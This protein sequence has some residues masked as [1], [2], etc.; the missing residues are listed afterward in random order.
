L[1]SG[2]RQLERKPYAETTQR[3]RRCARYSFKPTKESN[4]AVPLEHVTT[5]R[6]GGRCRCC[7]RVDSSRDETGPKSWGM[8]EGGCAVLPR[9]QVP[10]FR[11]LI[12][13]GEGLCPE[14][15]L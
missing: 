6:D 3:K 5:A 4:A 12:N 7:S 10:V 11:A 13:G 9:A 14:G 2:P 8:G 15:R 1:A